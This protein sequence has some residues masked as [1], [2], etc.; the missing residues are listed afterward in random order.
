MLII[1]PHTNSYNNLNNIVFTI[2]HI[3]FLILCHCS[4]TLRLIWAYTFDRL[5]CLRMAT[6]YS[7]SL[8]MSTI[9]YYVSKLFINQPYSYGHCILNFKFVT[10]KLTQNRFLKLNKVYEYKTIALYKK[11]L[12]LIQTLYQSV[13]PAWYRRPKPISKRL[14]MCMWSAAGYSNTD[15]NDQ[16]VVC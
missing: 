12:I 15:T 4:V 10:L 2:L 8:W 7:V 6:P 3:H 13:W 11:K 9:I 5:E 16:L 14:M 1:D